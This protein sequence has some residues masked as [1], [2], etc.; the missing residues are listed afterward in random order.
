MRDLVILG[1]T[2]SIGFQALEL[3]A[4]NP[5]KFRV[6]AITSAGNNPAVIIE[7]AK[8]FSVGVVGTIH[9]AELIREALPGI[10][11]IDG[12]NAA[13]EVASITCDVVLNAISGSI[14]LAA[15]VAALKVGNR[16]ALANKESLVAAGDFV[17]SLAKQ[18]QIIPVDSEHSALWQC[19]MAGKRNEVSRLVLTASG[20][21]FRTRK[22]MSTVTVDEALSHP[23]WSMG[24]V[25]SINSATLV[26]KAHEIIEAHHLYGMNYSQI[27]AVIHPQ[28]VIH[29]MVEFID[30]ATIA[31]ASPPNMKGPISYAINWP[32]RLKAATPAL[33][34]TQT[35]AWEFEPINQEKF[36]AIELAKRCGELG[37]GLPAI[38]NASNEVA[39]D[40]FLKGSIAFSS[41]MECV[42]QS[43]HRL[44]GS[45][46]SAIRDLGDVSAIEQDART[47]AQ[48]VLQRMVSS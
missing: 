2:G 6:V 30:G 5:G 14:G 39:V 25:I 34:W 7:Q 13:A 10:T 19:L 29:S 43:V 45:S 4:A 40:A 3:V 46:P 44:G 32:E 1:S 47:V 35:H 20:G 24:P 22:D 33:D 16:L 17:M 41:I 27:D 12:K 8:K 26:N 31:Q 21:P 23:T 28:S 48:E 37:G 11:V 15:T 42:E 36:P 9:N 38:F 18:D